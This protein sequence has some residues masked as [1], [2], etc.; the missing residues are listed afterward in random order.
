M[1]QGRDIETS[2]AHY[3][4]VTTSITTAVRLSPDELDLRQAI[5][6]GLLL[7]SRRLMGS[8]L[9]L[10]ENDE[11]AETVFA[12][13]RMIL[14]SATNLVFLLR[15]DNDEL[16]QDFVHSGLKADVELFDAIVSNI[17]SRNDGTEWEIERG[18]KKSV[19]R[20]VRDSRTTLEAVRASKRQ[21]GG[22]F[23]DRVR[24]VWDEDAYL[25]LQ[26]S[27]SSAVH[28]DWSN[29]LRFHISNS[30]SGY[31]PEPEYIV[32]ADSLLNPT[33][34][35]VSMALLEYLKASHPDRQDFIQAVG[36]G[37][38]TVMEAEAQS[39]DFDAHK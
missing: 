13:T 9:S 19:L 36:Q 1:R 10:I 23:Y 12:L 17:K 22:T 30:G 21:W 39:G 14:E 11:H 6:L 37:I 29:M 34:V 15:Q 26:R 7:R 4:R 3:V 5:E 25:Y 24:D 18:M 27:P 31:S 38:E 16:Y 2:V 20:Y 33:A 32:P 8:V 35:Y 28:G